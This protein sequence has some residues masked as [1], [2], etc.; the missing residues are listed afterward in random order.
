MKKRILSILLALFVMAAALP[1]SFGASAAWDISLSKTEFPTYVEYKPANNFPT[2][3]NTFQSLTGEP[4]GWDNGVTTAPADYAVF[5]G[6]TAATLVV[7]EGKA[8]VNAPAT[9][10]AQDNKDIHTMLLFK[11]LTEENTSYIAVHID[12]SGLNND[13][14]CQLSV[15]N[16]EQ[17]IYALT[18][19]EYYFLPDV[20][21][22][23]PNPEVE[24]RKTNGAYGVWHN[25]PF[26]INK[27]D[28]GTLY[29]PES[30]FGIVE[31]YNNYVDPETKSGA[32]NGD[33]SK[34]VPASWYVSQTHRSL[35]S[36]RFNFKGGM[37]VGD[38]LSFS[39]I[40]WVSE[41]TNYSDTYK[42]EY[43]A[44][45]FSNAESVVY[46][47]WA[48]NGK[49]VPSMSVADGVWSHEFSNEEWTADN[50]NYGST[51]ELKYPITENFEALKFDVD[52]SALS[53]APAFQITY[54]VKNTN[55]SKNDYVR[56]FI[57]S[58]GPVYFVNADGSVDSLTVRTDNWPTFSMPSGF[59]GTVVIPFESLKNL[60]V[61][62]YTYDG[63]TTDLF[64]TDDINNYSVSIDVRNIDFA[65]K[66]GVIT[67]DDFGFLT[68][69]ELPV[70]VAD[71]TYSKYHISENIRTYS[72]FEKN[73]S[74]LGTWADGNTSNVSL[75][76]FSVENGML[77]FTAPAQFNIETEATD[78][79]EA[80]YY[81]KSAI[82]I[83][84][85]SLPN[86]TSADQKA[87][88]FYI[89]CSA[90]T[91]KTY[92][93][94]NYFADNDNAYQPGI[95]GVVYLIDKDGN[96]TSHIIESNPWSSVL[97]PAGFEG[98]VVI[99]FTSYATEWG[100]GEFINT[101]TV[102]KETQENSAKLVLYLLE[103][104]PSEVCYFGNIDYLEEYENADLVNLRKGLMD[105]EG[106]LDI[107]INGDS[108]VDV[109]DI[110]R[111]K[112]VLA[113]AFIN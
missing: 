62:E 85:A 64:V 75:D 14:Y 72:G 24:V 30:L 58:G 43:I 88:S 108:F 93:R 50:L 71:Y 63:K 29:L 25:T 109:R 89:D 48:S 102:L 94:A 65:D 12:A 104:T 3:A 31:G 105:A 34:L 15:S 40:Q 45:D 10:E 47:S 99:P 57:V 28:K 53:V 41:A 44:E 83:T 5:S 61:G 2:A 46:S 111:L 92:L 54:N 97:L 42:Y 32:W 67:Y 13:E 82:G 52:L 60:T 73:S 86:V 27:G 7:T 110:V 96:I 70:P 59:K 19:S 49:G 106:G 18:A 26:Y 33:F 79:S 35:V 68:N 36:I 22:E 37:A 16:R 81:T 23:N 98:T 6:E 91:K 101:S 90:S 39:N 56:R 38:S 69:S 100:W 11:S 1:M 20:T 21:D 80:T 77:K 112:K 76:N 4:E 107:D 103:A 66:G 8:T 78:E 51:A 17:T 113:D 95:G 9:E 55:V 84:N 87:I 74:V